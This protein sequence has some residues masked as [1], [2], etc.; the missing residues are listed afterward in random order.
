MS[1]HDQFESILDEACNE[2]SP[3]GLIELEHTTVFLI[4]SK[5]IIM[6]KKLMYLTGLAGSISLTAGVAFTLLQM[7][8][9][10]PLFSVGL[11]VLLLVFVPLFTLERFKVVIAKKLSE[12]L[13]LILGA[14]AALITGLSVLF[15]IMHLQ[16]AD[17]LLLLGAFVFSLGFLPFLFFT[18]YKKSIA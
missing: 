15:K 17:V 8:G 16:G 1:T 12:R 7:P 2:L 9:G 18:M 3:E 5:R 14:T 13:K 6:M 4:N 11:L 10:Y